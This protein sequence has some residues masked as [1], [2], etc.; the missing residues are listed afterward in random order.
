MSE[1]LADRTVVVTGA[2]RGIGLAIARAFVRAGARV[3]MLARG[4]EA[5]QARATELGDAAIAIPC[6][7]SDRR[8]VARAVETITRDM[9]GTPDVLV[10]NAGLFR[11][12][13]LEETTV[14]QFT[15]T[16]QVNLVAPF[17]LVHA[18]LP[19]MRARG[20]GHIVTIGSVADRT[21]FPGNS[22]YAAS[23]FGARALHEVLR[24][25]LR[26][27][28]VRVTLVSPGSTDT[29]IW[30]GLDRAGTGRF[31][32]REAMLDADAVAAA[33]LYAVSQPPAVNVDELRLSRA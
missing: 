31:P 21:A 18:L 11:P 23:K 5:L 16:I 27:T 26:G 19:G 32:P 25:E 1:P 28:G 30:D 13:P 14:D 6:D 2:S 4:T 8:A 17:F 15:E 33:V 29:S 7:V 22:A 9:D 12:A 20:S 24:T 10:S 3:A